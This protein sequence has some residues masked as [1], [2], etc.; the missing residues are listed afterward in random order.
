MLQIN[1]EK[2]KKN[3]ENLNDYPDFW[4]RVLS[5]HRI[6]KDFINDE[7]KKVL[8]YLKDIRYEKYED[9]MVN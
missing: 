1:F 7:D 3:I 8:N 9:G 2:R 6:V 5:N 4:L